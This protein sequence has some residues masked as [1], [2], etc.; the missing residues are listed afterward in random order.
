MLLLNISDNAADAG[1]ESRNVVWKVTDT[2]SS[3]TIEILDPQEV[4]IIANGPAHE[5]SI[6]YSYS[7]GIWIPYSLLTE[8]P[9]IQHHFATLDEEWSPNVIHIRSLR[10]RSSWWSFAI[11]VGISLLNSKAI[12]LPW[13]Q[14]SKQTV[15]CRTSLLALLTT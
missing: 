10:S 13:K 8:T 12:T 7:I 1:A 4:V 3:F 2:R 14:I 6:T 5:F 11:L 15:G 9:F